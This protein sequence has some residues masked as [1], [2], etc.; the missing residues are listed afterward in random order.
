M[1]KMDHETGDTEIDTPNVIG[2]VISV[3]PPVSADTFLV[4]LR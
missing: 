3:F 4:V 2:E 1:A